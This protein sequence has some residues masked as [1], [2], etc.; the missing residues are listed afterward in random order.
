MM[1]RL[2]EEHREAF[3]EMA[4]L[5]DRVREVDPNWESGYGVTMS[6]KGNPPNP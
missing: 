4:M 3:I 6:L 5:E 2:G 1:T